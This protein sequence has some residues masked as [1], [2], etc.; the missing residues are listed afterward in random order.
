MAQPEQEKRETGHGVP[1]I[2]A[3]QDIADECAAWL[4]KELS[5]KQGADFDRA[6]AGSQMGKHM[7]VICVERVLR[8]YVSADLRK[9][10]DEDLK[11]AEHPLSLAKEIIDEH[12]GSQ[13]SGAA[14]GRSK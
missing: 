4:E 6:F 3:K 13:S 7:E 14:S 5:Q 11:H 9:A 1:L 12:S 8:Q 2:V 10:I